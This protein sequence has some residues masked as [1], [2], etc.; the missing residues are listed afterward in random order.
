MT[1]TTRTKIAFNSI[2]LVTKHT[3]AACTPSCLPYRQDKRLGIK[4]EQ[5]DFYLSHSQLWH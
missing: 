5:I 2:Y 1:Q 4:A 3:S